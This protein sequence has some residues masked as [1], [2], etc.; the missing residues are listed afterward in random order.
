MPISLFGGAVVL[1]MSGA[2]DP[3]AK[4]VLD[5][6]LARMGGL[7]ALNAVE[8]VELQVMTEWQRTDFDTRR[9]PVILS[10]EL[11]TE[12]RDYT[13][14]AWRYSRKFFSPNGTAEVIDLVTD[15]VAAIGMNGRW[16]AQNVAYVDERDEVFAFAPERVVRLAREA[17]DASM[18][19]DTVVAGVRYARVAATVAR[20]HPVLFF[21]RSDGLLA[22]ARVT[23]GQPNDFG[24]AAWGMMDVEFAYSRWQRLPDAKLLL[25]MQIDVSRVGRPYKRMT[26]I[27]AKINPVIPADSLVIADSLRAA[28]LATSRRPMFD[29]QTDS[30]RIVD[31]TFALFGSFGPPSGAVKI[32]GKWLLIEAGTAPLTIERSVNLLRRVDSSTS[33]AAALVTAPAGAGGIAW[34][35]RQSIVT[36]ITNT[37]APFADAALRGWPKGNTRLRAAT[38]QRWIRVG[39]DSLR[40]ESIDLPDYPGATVA[41]VPSLRWA[42]TWSAGP[43]QIDYVLAHIRKRGWHVDRIGSARSF[44]GTPIATSTVSR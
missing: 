27:S 2:P 30:A 20:F 37:A 34:L 16:R 9:P 35:T 5:T 33:I 36:W 14:P 41:Y 24:L 18:L 26:T 19:P 25:P 1:L 17:P 38:D 3:A 8:R 11:S 32:G 7:S 44:I 43:A 6:A 4:A 12:L 10:Y 40:V 42:Y 39:S 29:L 28:F 22:L 13:I 31:G 21:R 15:S 23:A